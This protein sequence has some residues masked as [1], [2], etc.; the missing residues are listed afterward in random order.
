MS[1]P[2]FAA[3]LAEAMDRAGLS[4]RRL[5]VRVPTEHSNI[6]RYLSGD[7][8]PTAGM[9]KQLADALGLAPGD[10]VRDGLLLAAGHRPERGPRPMGHPLAYDLDD[11]LRVADEAT[12]LWLEDGMAHL[13]SGARARIGRS[14]VIALKSPERAEESA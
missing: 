7:R 2:T 1:E 10:P 14:R 6:S 13:L 11:L 5:A 3:L 8:H 4:Q 9:V 12:R